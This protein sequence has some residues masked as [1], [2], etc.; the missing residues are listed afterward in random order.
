M[1]VVA[2]IRLVLAVLYFLSATH[3][4]VTDKSVMMVCDLVL[5][6]VQ[7]TITDGLNECL[8]TDDEMALYESIRNDQKK[9]DD[10]FTNYMQ[11]RYVQ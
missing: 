10:A 4:C 9:L 11:V 8:L 5:P 3:N 7:K 1:L 6:Q 2:S